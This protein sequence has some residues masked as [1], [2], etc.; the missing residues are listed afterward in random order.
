M[1]KPYPFTGQN[2]D[3]WIPALETAATW[4]NWTENEIVQLADHLQGRVL[5]E[6]NLIME[7]GTYRTAVTAL[8]SCLD[9]SNKILAA[10]D[11]RHIP[12]ED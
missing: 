6:C 2:F 12:Q 4:N 9:Q 8:R 1:P 5:E 7:C 10:L 11:S 3:D